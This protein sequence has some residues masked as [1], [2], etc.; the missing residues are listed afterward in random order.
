MS[1]IKRLR[2]KLD[3]LRT[4]LD[5]YRAV[6]AAADALRE[7]TMSDYLTSEEAYAVEDYD[8]VRA[9]LGSPSESPSKE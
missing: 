1:E 5:R 8:R 2:T 6:V 9:T 4:Q 7:A 3:L